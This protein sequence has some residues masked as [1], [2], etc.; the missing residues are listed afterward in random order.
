MYKRQRIE[1]AGDAGVAGEHRPG[2][3]HGEVEDLGDGAVVPRDLEG[4]GG[5]A[6]ASAVRAAGV[7][8]GEEHELDLDLPLTRARGA[9]SLGDVEREPAHA[10]AARLRLR[11]PGEELPDP[12]EQP[13]V[14]REARPG[15]APDGLLRDVDEAVDR[16][17]HITQKP[18]GRSPRSCLA[19]YTGLF[20]RV[21]QLFAGTPEAQARG[22]GVGRFSF[23]V[24][25]GRCPTCSGEGQIEVELVFLPGSYAR[26]PDCGGARYTAETLEITWNDRTVAEVLDLTVRDA[27][28]VFAGDARITRAL[29]ALSLIHISEPTRR[30]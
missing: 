9:A 6:G 7:A 4:L 15:A 21:R 24:P 18:I 5:V 26:C 27:R 8:A 10:P 11:G 13:G 20:D 3:A 28:P 19:T 22:W 30:S 2:V 23:N 12:V 17:V 29:D 25:E 16:L 14:R 1:R